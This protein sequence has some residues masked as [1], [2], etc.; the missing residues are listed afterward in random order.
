M[1]RFSKNTPRARRNCE[2]HLR[3]LRAARALRCWVARNRRLIASA[4]LREHRPF[5]YQIGTRSAVAVRT[6]ETV[7]PGC[8]PLLLL[9]ELRQ[10]QMAHA[11]EDQV[12]LDGLPVTHLEVVH[13]QF[14]LGVL[15]HPL[16]LEPAERN[17][18]KRPGPP[19]LRR[20]RDGELDHLRLKHVAVNHQVARCGFRQP[21]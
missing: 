21:S 13:P 14:A 5:R 4:R 6:C 8:F 18:Q 2:V 10:E 20:V 1:R 9:V 11:T 17:Q 7:R 19:R 12:P 16:D 3:W 15:E